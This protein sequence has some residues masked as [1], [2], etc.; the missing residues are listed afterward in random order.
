MKGSVLIDSSAWISISRG[1]DPEIQLK[2]QTL[3]AEGRAAMCW[4][5]WVELFQGAR[6]KREETNL[7]AWREYCVWLEFD[8]RCWET[9]AESSRACLRAGVNVPFG[10]ILADACARR[11][12][13]GLL[14]RDKHFAMIAKALGK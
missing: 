11:Y 14:E 12:G 3:L 8:A 6:G 1:G 5:V 10:D 9:A 4:P 13:A 7:R 2:A